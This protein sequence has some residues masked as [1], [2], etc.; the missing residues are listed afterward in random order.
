MISGNMLHNRLNGKGIGHHG[1]WHAHGSPRLHRLQAVKQ[2]PDTHASHI[3]PSPLSPSRPSAAEP[4]STTEAAQQHGSSAPSAPAHRR[5]LN[6][7][8]SFLP[9]SLALVTSPANAVASINKD[10]IRALEQQGFHAGSSTAPL[11]FASSSLSNNSS[12]SSSSA[13]TSSAAGNDGEG[14]TA[15]T[16]L[17]VSSS[18]DSKSQGTGAEDHKKERKGRLKVGAW[19]GSNS[20]GRLKKAKEPW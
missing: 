5:A 8:M 12:S 14:T 11:P 20:L 9:S 7:I 15:S 19:M 4:L 10:R 16:P 17:D 1:S 3:H 6:L 2:P 13:S 18:N